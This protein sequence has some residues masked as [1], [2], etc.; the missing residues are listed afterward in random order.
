[1][2][3]EKKIFNNLERSIKTIFKKKNIKIS[4]KIENLLGC[5]PKQLK[6]YLENQFKEDMTWQNQGRWHIDHIR[7]KKDFDLSKKK[8]RLNCFHYTNLQPL[9]A[10]ENLRKG[11]T[12]LPP[13]FPMETK[14]QENKKES[15]K[16]YI[17]NIVSPIFEKVAKET[18][19][20]PMS[21][22]KVGNKN[23]QYCFYNPHNYRVYYDYSKKG[24]TPPKTDLIKSINVNHRIK[25]STEHEFSNFMDC[26]ITIKKNL[27]EIRNH[28][29]HKKIF[30]VPLTE[31]SKQTFMNIIDEK[32]NQC[33]DVLEKFIN[34]FGGKSEFKLYNRWCENKIW[35]EDFIDGIRAKARWHTKLSKK[36]YNEQ[37]VEFYDPAFASNYI[38]NRAVESVLPS[39][40]ERLNLIEK[41]SLSNTNAINDM[42]RNAL[43]PLTEQIVL[44]L[45]VE[46]SALKAFDK[47]G[48]SISKLERYF[49]NI[50]NFMKGKI[51][52]GI[53]V[54]QTT[55]E[56]FKR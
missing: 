21:V 53:K 34:F 38:E 4:W 45:E 55:L 27:I 44:H 18:K 12:P 48:R 52:R 31:K 6:I 20:K 19:E 47:I 56:E 49:K 9:W 1:M 54:N 24:F 3:L 33:K 35:G 14:K 25:N 43:T 5:T 32:D 30:K 10:E 17:S 39:I 2:E 16:E 51:K 29:N 22:G 42:V 40:H 37:N 13:S 7:P 11:S 50:D 46:S 23:T 8:E 41:A 26:T 36:V 28:I 15:I